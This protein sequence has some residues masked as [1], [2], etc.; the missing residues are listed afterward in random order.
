MEAPIRVKEAVLAE[1]Y[2][3][4]ERPTGDIIKERVWYY[5]GWN[6]G[7]IQRGSVTVFSRSFNEEEQLNQTHI[8]TY[9]IRVY[10]NKIHV[11]HK[12]SIKQDPDLII[13][14]KP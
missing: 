2:K 4:I 12:K 1:I 7:N 13:K 11:Y 3:K 8:Y 14:Y 6:A 5:D 9:H 10:T